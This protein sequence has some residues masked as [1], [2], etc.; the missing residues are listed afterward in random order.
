MTHRN[1]SPFRRLSAQFPSA[2]MQNHPHILNI[3]IAPTAGRIETS[4]VEVRPRTVET[5][6]TSKSCSSEFRAML[7]AVKAPLGIPS[8]TLADFKQLQ[9]R[10]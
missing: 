6:S 10:T 2:A 8:I 4:P 9:K 1:F 7:A 5:F 3:A